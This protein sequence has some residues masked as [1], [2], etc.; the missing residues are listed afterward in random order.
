[1]LRSSIVLETG[2][3]ADGEHM[4]VIRDTAPWRRASEVPCSEATI[5]CRRS[6][7]LL[8]RWGVL[9]RKDECA[10]NFVLLRRSD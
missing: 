5:S 4:F 9:E 10:Y 7:G 3:K 6:L 8:D 2:F 1:M